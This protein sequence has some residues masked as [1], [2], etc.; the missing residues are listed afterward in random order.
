[1]HT[2]AHRYSLRR[3]HI[4]VGHAKW[5]CVMNFKAL[6]RGSIYARPNTHEH[7]RGARE[8]EEALRKIGSVVTAAVYMHS[9]FT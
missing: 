1:M 6:P 2:L 9:C 3:S 7:A 4:Q 8:Y 5:V